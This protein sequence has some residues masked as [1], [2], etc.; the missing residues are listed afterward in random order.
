MRYLA[1]RKRLYWIIFA[2][3]LAVGGVVGYFALTA[4]RSAASAKAQTSPAS[5]K[6]GGAVPASKKAEAAAEPEGKAA[7]P[8][9]VAS[10]QEGEV[11]SYITS[12]A[13]LVPENDVKV[14]AESE[15]KVAEIRVEEGDRVAKG[16]ILAQLDQGDAEITLKKAQVKA[17]NAKLNFDRAAKVL[18]ENLM[19]REQYDKVATENEV[20]RQEEAE[21]AWRLEKTTIR[22]PFSGHLT[23]RMIRPGQHIRPGDVLFSVADFD[24]LIA[25]IYLPEKDVLGL[26]E[27][28]GVRITLK[29]NETTQVKGRIRQISPVVDPATGTVKVTVEAVA[30]PPELRPGAF[31]TLA[32][33]RETHP[34]ALLVPREAILWEMQD[35]YLF[36]VDGAVARRR[37]VSLGLEE[38]GHVEVVRGLTAGDQV[39]V[40]GQ[41]GLK[42][43]ASVKVL[44]SA[45]ASDSRV[46]R[47][48]RARG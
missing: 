40:A 47:G 22:A 35:S 19:S 42:D 48:P 28:R 36:V 15:G 32:I 14:L 44:P 1:G 29:A 21:A 11:S 23:E 4:S 33:V 45:Q 5:G 6:P 20:A 39:I 46:S 25:R 24:P 31:V 9:S 38:E 30:P 18:A 2:V 10:I 34:K 3:I 37:P 26:T 43:G 41:G 16:E 7:V 27:G 17:S 12:T 8:V 13:N